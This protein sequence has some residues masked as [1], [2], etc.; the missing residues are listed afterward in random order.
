MCLDETNEWKDRHVSRIRR[1]GF[2]CHPPA[3]REPCDA[4]ALAQTVADKTG[5]QH[6]RTA[7]VSG[8]FRSIERFERGGAGMHVMGQLTLDLMKEV[9]MVCLSIVLP[10]VGSLTTRRDTLDRHQESSR[11]I[12][13]LIY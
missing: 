10:R 11:V 7:H 5:T 12:G 13:W 2:L 6:T 9:T 1:C 4:P 8:F 3:V